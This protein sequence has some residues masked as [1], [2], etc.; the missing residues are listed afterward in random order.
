MMRAQIR[1]DLSVGLNDVLLVLANN[2]QLASAQGRFD[3]GED[4]ESS[5][6]EQLWTWEN[7]IFRY[8]ENVHYQYRNDLYDEIEFLAQRKAWE[9]SMASSR[10]HRWHWCVWGPNYSPEFKADMDRLL[11][12][13]SCA[14]FK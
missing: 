6:E 14:E 8:W 12:T 9:R 7:A 1:N 2:Q 5:E 10:S 4:I 11:P 3:Q 13:G